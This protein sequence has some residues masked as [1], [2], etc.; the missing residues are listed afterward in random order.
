MTAASILMSD[1][2]ANPSNDTLRLVHADY[3][4]DN[5]QVDRADFI[6]VQVELANTEPQYEGETNVPVG[7][8]AELLLEQHRL[9]QLNVA[10][11]GTKLEAY[12]LGCLGSIRQ[13]F[14]FT[15]S[16]GFAEEVECIS[17][18]WL[19]HGH[20][21]VN[22]TPLSRV[23]LTDKRPQVL[24]SEESEWARYMLVSEERREEFP[25]I[26]E[27]AVLP[28]E[29]YNLLPGALVKRTQTFLF[30]TLV[31]ANKVISD[32]CLRHALNK[33]AVSK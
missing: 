27:S 23:T 13:S 5:N 30:K 25:A 9:S 3:L 15:F 31:E 17:G 12:F 21:I 26:L 18:D 11:Q 16:R 20:V 19:C 32:A 22:E 1:I 33:L 14:N 2:I 10:L 28:L 4:E 8:Y 6:R 29:L 24:W 7:R